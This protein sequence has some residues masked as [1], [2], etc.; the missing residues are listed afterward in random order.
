[1]TR[2]GALIGAGRGFKL[3]RDRIPTFAPA[4]ESRRP[5]LEHVFAELARAGFGP[6]DLFLA[7]DFT[8][9]SE[10]NLAGRM[11]H[12]RDDAFASIAERRP[13]F[14]VTDVQDNVDDR[15]FRRVTGT[16]TVPNY[17]TGN[18]S[19]AADSR[20]RR[21]PDPEALPVRNG[22]TSPPV[23]LQHPRAPTIDGPDP[24]HP[25]RASIYGHGLLGSN[26]E[27]NAGNVTMAN[28]HNFVFCATKWAGMSDD[29]VGNAVGILQDLGKF[30]RSPIARSR[31]S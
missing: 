9:A 12:I 20:T 2:A 15:I 17:L 31:A 8:V 27:V 13:A 22:S 18:G 7:W 23:H 1:M 30:P 26:D 21:A 28:E 6:S 14:T 4:I 24:V 5:H 16:F 11:L 25:A 3:Y 10:R 19:P 29:D